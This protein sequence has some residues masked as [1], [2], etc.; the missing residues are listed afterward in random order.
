MADEEL[1]I[2]FDPST[3]KKKKKKTVKKLADFDEGDEGL[4]G[5]KLALNL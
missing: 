5:E 2:N 1:N 3:A 4:K